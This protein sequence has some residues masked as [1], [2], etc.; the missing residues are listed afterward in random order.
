MSSTAVVI[1]AILILAAALAAAVLQKL[2]H[3][4][5]SFAVALIGLAALFFLLGAEFVGLLL[6]FVYIGAVAVLIVFTILLTGVTL[7]K[8]AV[9]I[10]LAHFWRLLSLA[11]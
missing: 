11:V 5:L 8:T 4:T 9:L 10:G 3:A 6:V 7:E 1:I 2:M